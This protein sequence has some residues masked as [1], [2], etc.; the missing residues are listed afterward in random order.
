MPFVEKESGSGSF[1]LLHHP[2]DPG[3]EYSILI[4][5][6]SVV[7][8]Q[9]LKLLENFHKLGS[10]ILLVVPRKKNLLDSSMDYSS[11]LT[12]LNL[13][14]GKVVIV[15]MGGYAPFLV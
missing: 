5:C 4:L 14:P 9:E 3:K 15:S 6:D 11:V 10:E 7:E 8:S 13:L 12:A 2:G 1:R